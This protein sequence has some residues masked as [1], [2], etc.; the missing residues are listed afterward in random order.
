MTFGT[1]YTIWIET[2]HDIEPGEE[3]VYDYAYILNERHTPAWGD[4]VPRN[5]LG[6]KR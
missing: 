3:L 4:Y 5:I 1:A 6:R 2:L